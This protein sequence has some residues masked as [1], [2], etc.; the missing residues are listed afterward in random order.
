MN[1]DWT[2][3]AKIVHENSSFLLTSHM[4]PDCD[5]LGSELGMAGLLESLGKS[6]RIV[7]GDSVPPH[8]SFIDPQSKI[9]VLGE[10]V[11]ERIVHQVDVVMVL[12]TSAWGQLGPM[13]APIRSRTAL[14]VI[15][16]HHVSEDEFPAERFKDVKA[17][18]TG[19]LVLAAAEALKISVTPQIATPLFAAIATDTGWFRFPSVREATLSAAATLVAHG[20]E[21]ALLFSQ[22][23]EQHNLARLKLRGKILEH[24]ATDVAGRLIYSKVT[25][26]DLAET[27]A[28]P[29]DTEDAINMLLSVA[30]TQVAILF[31][32]QVNGMTKVS[33]RSRSDIDV[34]A[35]AERFGGGGHLAAAGVSFSGTLAEAESAILDAAR[36]SMG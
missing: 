20:A 16:D 22:L 26:D 31:T 32:E 7:N 35:I 11:D 21:P 23:Y 10:H 33:L 34:R 14:L 5:A 12:D 24:V 25:R 17:A 27:G 6:V 13:A 18:A 4:R 15:V 3:F 19:E 1:I 29:S 28:Q 8:L 30:G 9:E 36:E 2:R